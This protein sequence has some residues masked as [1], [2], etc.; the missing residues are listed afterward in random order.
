M[1]NTVERRL[2]QAQKISDGA[3]DAFE[4]AAEELEASSILYRAVHD[5]IQDQITQLAAQAAHASAA[6]ILAGRRAKKIR[7]FLS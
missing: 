4:K 2:Q 1:R 6:G 5:D 3:L 7:D